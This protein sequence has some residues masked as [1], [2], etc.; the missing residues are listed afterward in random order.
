MSDTDTRDRADLADDERVELLETMQRIRAFESRVEELFADRE[1]PGFVHLYIGEEAVATGVCGALEDSDYIT[2]THRGHGHCIAKG[3]ELDRM[4]AEL[5]GRETGYC[6]G[7]GGSMHI[8]SPELNNLGANGIVGAG[9]PIGVGAALSSHL[10]DSG[11]VAVSFFGDGALAQGAFHEAMNLAAVWDLPFVAVV[12]NNH[13]GEMSG[14]EEQ[15]AVT[16]LTRRAGSYGVPAV[17]VD[18]MDVED[19]YAATTAAAEAAR[20]GEGPTLL[21]CE[22]YRFRGHHEGDSEA[23]RDDEEV[24]R[25]RERDPLSTYPERL[26]SAGALTEDDWEAIQEEVAAEVDAAVEFARESDYPEPEAAYAN[27]FAE[28]V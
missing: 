9:V 22:T 20:A 26:R 27:L 24:R 8:A 5:F 12:E 28:E 6:G 16:D 13:Y 23:Y 19:V 15:Q 7:K 21:V 3:H 14:L 2:S 1:L 25:W 4:M 10:R 11:Q 17:D 18:G